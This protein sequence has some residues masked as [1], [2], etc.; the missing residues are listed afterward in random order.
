MQVFLFGA[1]AISLV[2]VLFALQNIV[3]VKVVFL[4][5]QFEG[6]LALVL[7]VAVVVGALIS[8]LASLPAIIKGRWTRNHQRKQI[9]SLE[10]SLGECQRKLQ[11]A[12]H[13]RPSTP[14]PRLDGGGAI[15]PPT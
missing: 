15:E 1:L 8:T 11:A 14:A 7:F 13:E 6:S 3:P 12:E 5:W 4:A 10:A 9:A 2:A